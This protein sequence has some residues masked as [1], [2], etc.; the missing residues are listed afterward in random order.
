MGLED[1]D[2]QV[3]DAEIGGKVV[4]KNRHIAAGAQLGIGIEGHHNEHD[5]Y[6]KKQLLV[7]YG[8]ISP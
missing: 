1:G 4:I 5:H 2:S 3:V 8:K 6:K 7:F